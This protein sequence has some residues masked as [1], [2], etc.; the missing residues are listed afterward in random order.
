MIRD[1]YF[2][3]DHATRVSHPLATG[4]E[5]VVD[6]VAEGVAH[7]AMK[8]RQA[9]ARAHSGRQVRALGLLDLHT[10]LTA[11][12]TT[13]QREATIA[14]TRESVTGYEI[15]HGQTAAGVGVVA[16]LDDRLGWTSGNVTG[17]YLHGLFDD[18][19]YLRRFLTKIGARP[20]GQA[21]RAAELDAEFDRLAFAVD[22]TGWTD[23]IRSLL[24]TP[25]GS[26]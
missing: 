3:V 12:K 13:S 5:L 15:H 2:I 17:V 19:N 10:V 8:A 24:A 11:V 20:T 1:L 23:H 9:H 25:S 22:A 18:P 26:S 14:E 4:H 16:E 6:R 7:A 21:D